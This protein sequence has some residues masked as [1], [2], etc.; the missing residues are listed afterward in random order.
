M[1]S[2]SGAPQSKV[3][4]N[5]VVIISSLCEP[6]SVTFQ[7]SNLEREASSMAVTAG[8]IP[9]SAV[10]SVAPESPNCELRAVWNGNLSSKPANNSFAYTK[11]YT[12]RNSLDSHYPEIDPVRREDEK[13]IQNLHQVL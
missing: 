10:F 7:Q 2:I 8:T 3:R 13:V 9:N 12:S 4:G 6:H 5:A 1:L 11:L